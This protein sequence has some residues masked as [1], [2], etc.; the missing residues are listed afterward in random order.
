MPPNIQRIFEMLDLNDLGDNYIPGVTPAIGNFMAQ[1]GA[2]CLDSSG[3]DQGVQLTIRGISDHKYGL[4]WTTPTAQAHRSW[5]HNQATEWGAAGIAVLLAKN[6]TP[7]TVIEAATQGTGIDYWL[8]DDSDIPFQRKARLEISG[9]RQDSVGI[10]SDRTIAARV[11]EKMRQT[12]QSD[13]TNTP[14]YVIV[15]EFGHPIA[16]VHQT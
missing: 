13:N 5:Q 4:V 6:E 9:I 15:V 2:V 14:A 12:I 10:A 1:A 16:E 7:Y 11:R 3:H 8:G